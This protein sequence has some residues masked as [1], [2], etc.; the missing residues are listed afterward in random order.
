MSSYGL[1]A[2]PKHCRWQCNVPLMTKRA[3]QGTSASRTEKAE[4]CSRAG[5]FSIDTI[6]SSLT[7]T[8]NE[9]QE[10]ASEAIE[11]TKAAVQGA[12]QQA[13]FRAQLIQRREARAR[14]G[15]PLCRLLH[16]HRGSRVR[17]FAGTSVLAKPRTV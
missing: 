8:G 13:A 6:A 7:A 2:V 14:C 4:A 9:I 12:A 5:E 16:G 1:L 15:W 17:C 10:L 3:S 11:D